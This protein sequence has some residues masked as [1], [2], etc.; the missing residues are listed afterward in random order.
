MDLESTSN[1]W[2]KL[3]GYSRSTRLLAC[4]GNDNMHGWCDS[5]V[6]LQLASD[7]TK[8]VEIGIDL[9][10][11]ILTLQPDQFLRVKQSLIAGTSRC[12]IMSIWVLR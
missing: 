4:S 1:Q 12:S 11:N 5:T 3:G 6:V 9:N 2:H 7:D 10:P 8:D